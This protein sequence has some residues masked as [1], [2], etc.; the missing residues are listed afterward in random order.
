MDVRQAVNYWTQTVVS[1]SDKMIN[2]QYQLQQIIKDKAEIKVPEGTMHS[3]VSSNSLDNHLAWILYRSTNRI[4]GVDCKCSEGV[5]CLNG[6]TTLRVLIVGRGTWH[7]SARVSKRRPNFKL[8]NDRATHLQHNFRIFL[9]RMFRGLPLALR[10]VRDSFENPFSSRLRRNFNF[11]TWKC[12]PYYLL[13][14]RMPARTP[15]E[16]DLAGLY[17]RSHSRLLRGKSGP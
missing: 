2:Q 7:C 4:Q 13:L 14:F 3:R 5:A 15:D 17:E 6:A 9:F 10:E 12:L 11:D 16:M 8:H 1:V